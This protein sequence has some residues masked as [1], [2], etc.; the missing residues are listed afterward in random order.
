MLLRILVALAVLG[1]AHRALAGVT[2]MFWQSDPAA[3]AL[4]GSRAPAPVTERP[5][6]AFP[7]SLRHCGSGQVRI[8]AVRQVPLTLRRGSRTVGRLDTECK[9]VH[10]AVPLADPAKGHGWYVGWSHLSAE[11][12][13]FYVDARDEIRLRGRTNS[14]AIG[15]AYASADGWV[16]GASCCDHDLTASLYGDSLDDFQDLPPGQGGVTLDLSA[17]ATT[18]A[19]ERALGDATLGLQFAER[20]TE[21]TL[22]VQVEHDHYLAR[23]D[24]IHR[25]WDGY[26]CLDRGRDRWFAH[27]SRRSVGGGRDPLGTRLAI[28]GREATDVKTTTVGLG[29][30]RRTPTALTQLELSYEN[31]LLDFSAWLDQGILGGGLTGQYRASGMADIDTFALRYGRQEAHGRWQLQYG[32]SVLRLEF[33]AYG[34]Y[35]DSPGVFQRPDEE[36]EQIVSDGSGWL[37]SASV[38]TG[39][40]A[41]DWEILATYSLHG[42]TL[43]AEAEDLLPPSPPTPPPEPPPEPPPPPHKPALRARL[44]HIFAIS[45]TRSL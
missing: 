33:D 23:F 38:G 1:S 16:F 17:P 32:L 41:R 43:S 18:V 27:G 24:G 12:D 8:D 21:A 26:C 36:F 34:R 19:V 9:G 44:G 29:W 7:T 5:R 20:R 39:Y 11:T 2:D 42:G 14:R 15:A 25:A 31:Y 30:R 28:R 3:L 6:M 10:M 13:G 37:F 45:F 40:R 22:P 4:G 35:V